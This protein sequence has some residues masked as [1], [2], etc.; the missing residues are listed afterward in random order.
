MKQVHII[1]PQGMLPAL[2]LSVVPVLMSFCPEVLEPL[3]L[4]LTEVCIKESVWNALGNEKAAAHKNRAQPISL[5]GI[6]YIGDELVR[7]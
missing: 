1:C 5:A 4:T 2:D 6:V 7:K 3:I